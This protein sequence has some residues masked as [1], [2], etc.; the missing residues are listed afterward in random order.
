MCEILGQALKNKISM[1]LLCA[2]RVNL[3]NSDRPLEGFQEPSWT[4]QTPDNHYNL[5]NQI[6]SCRT[7]QSLI[8]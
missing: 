5:V 2:K 6:I 1:V 8:N 4:H 7:E 3:Q